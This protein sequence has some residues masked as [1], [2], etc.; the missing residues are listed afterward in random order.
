M[1][2]PDPIV[3]PDR[4]SEDADRALRPQTLDDFIGQRDARANLKVFITRCSTARPAW[5]R[6]RW[7]R[8]WPASLV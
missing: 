2:E 3:R 1:N 8:L 4:Q 5:V 6:Q 7:H